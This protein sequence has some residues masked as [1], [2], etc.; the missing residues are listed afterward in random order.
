MLLELRL[1]LLAGR[2]VLHREQDEL[3]IIEAAR[4]QQDRARANPL[5]VMAH[6]IVVEDRI[7]RQN[8]FQQGMQLGNIPLPI[9]ELIDELADGLR[10][11]HLKHLVEGRIGRLHAEVG[12]EDEQRFPD[13]LDN[14]FGGV[15]GFAEGLLTMLS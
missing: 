1:G 8:L 14:L 4:V 15:F 12:R 13:R 3:D 10:W 6:L 2:D 9:A 5:K 11:A 7:L